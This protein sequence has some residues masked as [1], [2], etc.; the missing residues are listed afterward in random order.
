MSESTSLSELDRDND[1]YLNTVEEDAG[2]N[3]D[4]NSSTPKTVAEDLYNEAKALLDSLNAEKATLSD[5]GFTKYEVADL[6]DKSSQLENLKQKALDAAEYVHKEDGKQDLIDKIEKLAFTVPDETNHSNTTWVGGTML[7]GSMLGDEPVVLSTKLDSSFRGKDV[8]ELAKTEQTIDISS[9]KLK[10]PDSNTPTLLDSDWK[11]TRPNGSGGGYTK[12]KVEGGKIIFQVDPEKAEV[13]DG[14]TNEVFTVESD[15]GSML[16]YV[17]SLAGT[18]KKIDI[19]NI[20]I[21][22]NLSDL[23]T[24]NIPNGDH[25]NDKRFE[26]I[27]VKLNGDVDKETFVKLS[28]K[29]SAGEVVVSG[30]KNISNG[31]EL[32]FDILSSKD[33]ADGKYTFEATKV[34]DSKG[35][36]IANERVVKHEIVVDTVAPVIETSY[37]VDSHGKP[38]VNFYTDE[39]ALYIFDD[40][41][42][43]NNKVSAWQSKV[44][45]STDTRFEAQEGHKYFFFDKAGNYSEVVV[46]I[47]KV[48]NR[49]TADMTTGT[50]PD[51]ATKDAD[52]AQGTS[53]S[54]QFK[55]TNGDDNIIIYKA[56]NSG[57]EYAGFIDGGTGR[58]EKAITLDTAGG[59]DTI[60]ARG[61]GGHTN[62]NTGE[63]NDKIILDQGI[64]GYGPNSVYYGGMNGPQTINMG[65]GND[66]LKVGKFSMWNNGESVNSFY[67]TTTRILMGDGNDVIDVAG[68][69]WADSD[70]GEPYSNYINLGRGDDS[71]HIGGKLADTFNTGTN[72]VYASN[73]IDLGSGKDALTVDG[74]VEGNALILSDDAST[75]TLNS[76]VTGLAT[77]VLGSGED[78]VTFKEAVSFGGG[79]YE[80]IS[81]VVN[82]YLENKKAGAPNQNWYAESASK[83]D[84]LDVLMKPFIDLGDGNNTLTFENTLANADIKSGNGNDTITISN[85]LSNSN[86][87]TGAGAD[88]VFVENWNTATKIKVDLGDGNDTIEVSSLGRQN[89]NSPQIFQNVIDGGDGY[90]V[91]NTNKQEITL[92]MYAKDKVNTISLVNMEEINLN[93]TSMLH[94][95]TSG[96]LKAITVDNKSQYSAEIFVNG[97][98]KDIVNLE[99]FQSD[100]HRW[101]LTNNNI[102]VQ[103]HNGTYNE[104][105]YTVDN[106]NTNIKL[107]LSTDIKTVHEIVI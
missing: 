103:D 9:D 70:N 30:V 93:G 89:G 79:Y 78:V 88:H 97:H 10:D 67:K 62:I 54:S 4:D 51:N 64:I 49:L 7:N 39:T 94:V 5:G 50:G 16:R 27:T 15:D 82:T 56:A 101:K 61:I 68:T 107:Y 71:L 59:N 84:K 38:F 57:E 42:K 25:T 96:G 98:D 14:N 86:I 77:F 102:K 87:A 95:G 20:L 106:Q 35:N 81:P 92:N 65:A 72:V 44:P 13:L 104:Y 73:V 29:N 76:K 1:G 3:P 99:R 46:S 53:D 2:S 19:A 100:E 43:T 66:T 21:A 47:P 63:G 48:L 32:T 80:S 75:I 90:D 41:N 11:Y 34:A 55:T 12:Y 74:A 105:T 40:N 37:E 8:K 17:V 6:R 85:T 36:T 26:T 58:G 23:K 22:D 52:K 60:Q 83:L 33:L 69:V 18:S 31:S 45:M 24:G 28:V 91:F